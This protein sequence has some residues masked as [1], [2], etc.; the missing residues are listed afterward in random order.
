M[1]LKEINIKIE[2]LGNVEIFSY[3]DFILACRD[4]RDLS[5]IYFFPLLVNKEIL[6]K[7]E[8][9]LTTYLDFIDLMHKPIGYSH[10]PKYDIEI[11]ENNNFYTYC[12]EFQL[13]EI[14]SNLPSDLNAIIKPE[15][16]IKLKDFAYMVLKEISLLDEKFNLNSYYDAGEKLAINTLSIDIDN[17]IS[18]CINRLDDWSISFTCIDYKKDIKDIV[19]ILKHLFEMCDKNLRKQ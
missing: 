5:A 3:N 17:Y 4:K 6:G 1:Q 15:S 9:L 10:T 11:K 7:N 13:I 12:N 16:S 19:D 8:N 2:N 18:I 14:I